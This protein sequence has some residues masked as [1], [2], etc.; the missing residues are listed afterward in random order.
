MVQPALLGLSAPLAPLV[1]RVRLA[2]RVSRAT[3]ETPA[4]RV[5]RATRETP[6]TRALR[7]KG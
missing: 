7:V 3:R 4:L 6:A 1:Q 5:S 2:L